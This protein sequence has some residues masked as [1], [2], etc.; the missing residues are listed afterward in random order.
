[1]SSFSLIDFCVN[2]ILNV[3]MKMEFMIPDV[4]LEYDRKTN[5]SR[6]NY[7]SIIAKTYG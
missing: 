5:P 7:D 3:K 6:G 1:M 4:S 2:E